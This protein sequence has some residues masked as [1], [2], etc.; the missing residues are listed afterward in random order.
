[1]DTDSLF[2]ENMPGS[3]VLQWTSVQ[4]KLQEI[5]SLANFHENVD[6]SLHVHGVIDGYDARMIY[7]SHYRHLKGNI[8]IYS[9]LGRS[10]FLNVYA[11]YSSFCSHSRF[12]KPL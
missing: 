1:M 7:D 5:S 12:C 11:C 10:C 9:K 4:Y 2:P 3:I 6:A 8:Y